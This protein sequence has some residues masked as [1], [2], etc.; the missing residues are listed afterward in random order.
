MVGT[1]RWAVAI[2]GSAANDLLGFLVFSL[3]DLLDLLLCFAYKL[4][5]YAAEAQW[6]PCY[7]FA[8]PA[9]GGARG[10]GGVFVLSVLSSTKLQLEDIS[11]TLFARPS[12]VSD[13]ARGAL[14]KLNVLLRGRPSPAAPVRVRPTRT[15]DGFTVNNSTVVRILQGKVGGDKPSTAPCWSDCLCDS[16]CPRGSPDELYVYAECPK[17]AVYS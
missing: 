9:R 10:S 17:G 11:D 5:D 12:V 3:L 6:K 4:A 8:A 7:C 2:A 13:V 16:C 14:R 15:G 1:V